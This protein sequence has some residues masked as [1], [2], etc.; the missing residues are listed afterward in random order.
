MRRNPRY[1]VLFEPVRPE[2]TEA[3]AALDS[4]I[5]SAMSTGMTGLAPIEIQQLPVDDFDHSSAIERSIMTRVNDIH[6]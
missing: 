6:R 2:A 5:Y 3:R 4:T 1:D